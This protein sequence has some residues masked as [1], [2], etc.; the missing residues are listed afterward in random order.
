MTAEQY[1]E[2]TK[3]WQKHPLDYVSST[4]LPN[5]VY[6]LLF[7]VYNDNDTVGLGI[8][9]QYENYYRMNDDRF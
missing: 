2:H 3:N 5:G 1:K 6:R 8:N 9:Y 7:R 4:V